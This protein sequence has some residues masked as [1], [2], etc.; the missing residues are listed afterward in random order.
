[1]IKQTGGRR[2]NAVQRTAIAPDG[3]GWR[4]AA[5]CRGA[6]LALFFPEDPRDIASIQAIC[7]G[8]P[9]TAEC[10]RFAD[11]N[12]IT[13]GIWAGVERSGRQR[14]RRRREAA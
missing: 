8:C 5:A 10:R 4:S 12:G 3:H 7:A 14:R 11:A 2:G 1:M 6:D 13:D 9:V